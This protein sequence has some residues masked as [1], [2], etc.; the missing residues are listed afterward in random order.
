MLVAMAV[1]LMQPFAP[2]PAP[3]ISGP[4]NITRP[5]WERQPAMA[6]VSRLYPQ[7]LLDAGGGA[8]VVVECVAAPDGVLAN[9]HA[10]HDPRPGLGVAEAALAIVAYFRLKPLDQA[11]VPVVGRRIRIPINLR[12]PIVHARAEGGWEILQD[13]Y[14][15]EGAYP[16]KALNASV[17]GEA[18]VVCQGKKGARKIY[19]SVEGET[20]TGHGFGAAALALQKRILVKP[21]A[22]GGGTALRMTI[23]FRAPAAAKEGG[24]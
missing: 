19:C 21:P 11:G 1:A 22:G 15:W 6:Q 4:G 7:A 5:A 9:C 16:E 12:A 17:S 13:P 3:P 20:P 24:S 2:P 8:R 10:V 23:S 14:A 18:T